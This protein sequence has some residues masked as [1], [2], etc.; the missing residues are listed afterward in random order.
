MTHPSQESEPRTKAGKRLCDLLDASGIQ[1][2]LNVA[3]S[4]RIRAIEEQAATEARRELLT[5]L[6]AAV[7][8]E[9]GWT[10]RSADSLDRAAVIALI[11]E[12]QP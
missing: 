1:T 12:P 9:F 11:E 8:Q 4:S 2:L 7:Q 3:V 6:R 10:K 5:A